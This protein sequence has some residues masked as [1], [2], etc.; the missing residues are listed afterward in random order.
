MQNWFI[1]AAVA[2]ALFV[3]YQTLSK[4][5]PKGTST[6]LVTAY[7][8]AVGALLMLVLHFALSPNKTVGTTTRNL[9]IVAGMGIF[10][11]LGNFLIIKA[12]ASG[13]PQSAWTSIFNPL[14]ILY[15]VAVGLLIWHKKLSLP[16]V[17]GVALSAAGI[18]LIAYFRA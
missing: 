4:L 7:A 8:L 17:G 11:G 16:Q 5:L 1:L 14:Y 9:L 10:I 13:A 6:Y 18:I 2:P 12:L 3:A 15:G